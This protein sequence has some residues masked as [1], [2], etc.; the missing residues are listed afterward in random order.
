MFWII[1]T[2]LLLT[3]LT[4]IPLALGLFQRKDIPFFLFTLALNSV[5]NIALN[6][7]LCALPLSA[8]YYLAVALGEV[9]VYLVEALAYGLFTQKWGFSFFASLLLNG[10]SLILGLLMNFTIQKGADIRAYGLS[11]SFLVLIG[12]VYYFVFSFLKGKQAKES[13]R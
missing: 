11:F 1:L 8:N 9:L 13:E 12:L 7:S 6:V 4:E 3:L 2:P 5:T 10:T